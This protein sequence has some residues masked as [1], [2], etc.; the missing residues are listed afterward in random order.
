[1][2]GAIRPNYQQQVD[3][4]STR[5]NKTV[6]CCVYWGWA[7]VATTARAPPPRRIHKKWIVKTRTPRPA[8]THQPPPSWM[9]ER[10]TWAKVDAMTASGANTLWK[11][12]RIG[13][14]AARKLL[15]PHHRHE[16][17]GFTTCQPQPQPQ[18][19]AL[20]M[21]PHMGGYVSSKACEGCTQQRHQH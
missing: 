7:D 9:R 13:E 21:N 11:G 4:C 1:M 2:D 20:Q 17:T 10:T 15:A 12:R 6:H 3:H 14:T 8:H 5:G 18:P 16:S 19:H